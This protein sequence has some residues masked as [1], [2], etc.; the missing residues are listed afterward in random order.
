VTSGRVVVVVG[1]NVVVVDVVVDVLVDV[2]ELAV[3]ITELFV[4]PATTVVATE[5]PV[6]PCADPDEQAAIIR[7]RPAKPRATQVRRNVGISSKYPLRRTKCWRSPDYPT[8]S[9]SEPT[10]GCFAF[11][12]ERMGP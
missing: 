6:A 5:T 11:S 7:R 2:V 10:R 3:V 4:D 9:H 8:F 12:S 1:T